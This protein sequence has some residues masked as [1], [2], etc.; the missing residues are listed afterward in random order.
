MRRA[1]R[2]A[3]EDHLARASTRSIAPP[4][5]NSTPTARLP[6]NTTRCTSA[7]VTTVEVRPLQRRA[8]IGAR[9]ALAAPAAAGLLH[10]ADI[11][12]G[13]GRQMVDV[14]VVFEADL[15]AGLDDLAG[16]APACRRFARSGAARR[17]VKLVGAALPALGPLE[18]R[19]HVVPR[20]AAIAE[21]APMV[22]ILGLAADIDHAVDR[23]RAAEH[24]AA[25]IEDRAVVDAG[26]GLGL[27]APGQLRMVEQLHIAGRDVDERVPV[28]PAGLDQDDPV[29]GSADSR[30]ASTHPADRRRRSRN[31]LA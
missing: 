5:E 31:P 7:S 26:I 8:Q 28:A 19:Q 4:R 14:L 18:I 3:G 11:V 6:S 12:A 15:G 21:L 27:E 17:A 20:P 30:F 29:P 16:T 22:E 24:A 10:P 2:A 13:A 23:L 9:R 25:R 1:D